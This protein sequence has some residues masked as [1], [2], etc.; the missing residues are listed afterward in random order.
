MSLD[1]PESKFY[2]FTTGKTYYN[3]LK[4]AEIGGFQDK[5]PGDVKFRFFQW[6][7]TQYYLK[8]SPDLGATVHEFWSFIDYSVLQVRT[9]LFPIFWFLH[10]LIIIF[11]HI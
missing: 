11:Y 5:S 7:E 8:L 10:L 4:S 2:Q 6:G 1:Q 9:I 3:W